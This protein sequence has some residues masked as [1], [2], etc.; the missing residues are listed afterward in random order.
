MFSLMTM[1]TANLN[2]GMLNLYV[3]LETQLASEFT[4]EFLFTVIKLGQIAETPL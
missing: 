4:T 2:I 3:F 1:L